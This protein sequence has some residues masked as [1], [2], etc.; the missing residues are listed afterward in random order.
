[1]SESVPHPH[2]HTYV[3]S[4]QWDILLRRLCCAAVSSV[5]F[6][7]IGIHASSTYSRSTI[8]TF[9]LFKPYLQPFCT[10]QWRASGIVESVTIVNTEQVLQETSAEAKPV[11]SRT[12]S[13]RA[14]ARR[15]VP[16]VALADVAQANDLQ[17]WIEE[18]H[19][20]RK[21]WLQAS[22]PSQA[23]SI[24]AISMY[25]SSGCR[26][27]RITESHHLQRSAHSLVEFATVLFVPPA[28]LHPATTQPQLNS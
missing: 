24:M 7:W 5:S 13:R 3:I 10:L 16:R 15:L 27:H 11:S 20:S 22:H 8:A 6:I 28:P 18:S 25:R 14:P 2:P 9:I 17:P 12:Q 19:Q 1:M 21:E 23:V 4:R 26:S